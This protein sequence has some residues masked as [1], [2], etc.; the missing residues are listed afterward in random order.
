MAAA[1]A[2]P[3]QVPALSATPAIPAVV[4]KIRLELA[5]TVA[6]QIKVELL[7]STFNTSCFYS[8]GM[9]TF[10]ESV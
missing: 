5:T 7:A 8:K 9:S 1:V 3:V 6:R 4:E 10:G 2:S